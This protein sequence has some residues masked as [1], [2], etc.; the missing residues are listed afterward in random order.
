M[1]ITDRKPSVRRPTASAERPDEEGRRSPSPEARIYAVR[2]WPD[3]DRSGL[4]T[5]GAT[6]H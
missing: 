4:F 3:D 5:G 6:L 2:P 1:K